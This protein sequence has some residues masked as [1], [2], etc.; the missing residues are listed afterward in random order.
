MEGVGKSLIEGLWNGIKNMGSWIAKKIQGFGDSVLNG[1]KDFFGIKSPSKVMADEVGK[2]LALGIGQG[3]EK[4]IGAVNSD[5]TD[6]MNFESASV[7]GQIG[8]VGLAKGGTVINYTNN[9]K[10][11][12]TSQKEKYK[13]QQSLL[14]TLRLAKVGV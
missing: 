14:A 5:I 12:F 7:G 8:G 13:A 4:N 1:L 9:F 10:Q 3:F 6:A 2:N 11:A